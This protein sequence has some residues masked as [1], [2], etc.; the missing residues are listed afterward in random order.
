M[1]L[2]M[3]TTSAVSVMERKV[4]RKA[5]ESAKEKARVDALAFQLKYAVGNELCRRGCASGNWRQDGFQRFRLLSPRQFLLHPRL[6]WGARVIEGE[7]GDDAANLHAVERFVLEQS[8]RQT[9]HRVAVLIDD[10][11]GALVLFG[12]DLAHFSVD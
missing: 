12:D 11:A 7:T 8:L 1:P 5:D 4:W 3:M 10:L 2:P 6:A 9:H